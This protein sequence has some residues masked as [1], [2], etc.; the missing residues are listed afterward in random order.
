MM[1][2]TVAN[3][4]ASATEGSPAVFEFSLSNPSAVDTTYTFTFTN[5]TAGSADYTTTSQ[6]VTVRVLLRELY[7]YT[8]ADTIAESNE[9]YYCLWN[10]GY[11]NNQ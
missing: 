10:F 3:A 11:W 8:T 6:T 4:P 5:G 2:L 7:L 1:R 9:T